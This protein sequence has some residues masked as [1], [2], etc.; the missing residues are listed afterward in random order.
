[1]ACF[2]HFSPKHLP[3]S[4]RVGFELKVCSHTLKKKKKS[5]KKVKFLRI[6]LYLYPKSLMSNII[7]YWVEDIWL[8]KGKDIW[9][10]KRCIKCHWCRMWPSCHRAI[11]EIRGIIRFIEA[12]HS[13]TYGVQWKVCPPLFYVEH[14]RLMEH[15]FNAWR[16][17]LG[18]GAAGGTQT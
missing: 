10:R 3:N 17:P 11:D 18:R 9:L 7:T 14:L 13:C 6:F 15:T 4:N 1:M 16:G 8:T 12:V 2:S 5:M